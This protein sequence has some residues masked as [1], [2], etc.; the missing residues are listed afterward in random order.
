MEQEIEKIIVCEICKSKL[1]KKHIEGRD[2]NVTGEL[3]SIDECESCGYRFTNPRP[4]E[5]FIGKYYKSKN[6]ISHNSTK[7]GLVNKAYHII[8]IYQFYIKNR[9]IEKHK[10]TYGKNLLDIGCGTGDFLKYM[11]GKGWKVEGVEKNT[12]ARKIAQNKINIDIK[13]D[14]NLLE[15]EEKYDIVTMWHVLEHVYGV[16]HY[17]EKV[18]RLLKKGGVL[19]IA[20]PNSSS[21]DARKYKKNW[22]AYDLPIHCS[23]FR[24]NDIM[25]IANKN[26]F[27]LKHVIPMIFDA[28]YISM[29]SSQKKGDGLLRGFVNGITSNRKAKKDKEYSSLMYFLYK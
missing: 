10:E 23:H 7:K 26:N 3:F 15:K 18:Y 11:G 2:H 8:R 25:N 29:L 6:Y 1:L 22:V 16:Q 27:K 28:Y 13:E 21:Y 9:L 20:V 19:I 4:K 17:V 12:G 5:A 24:K 14:I